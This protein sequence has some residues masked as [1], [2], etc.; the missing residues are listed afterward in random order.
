MQE[1]TFQ[2]R[3]DTPAE[4]RTLSNI[5]GIVKNEKIKHDTEELVKRFRGPLTA[6]WPKKEDKRAYQQYK[7]EHFPIA[8][9]S[10]SGADRDKDT[11]IT[12]VQHTGIINLDI[13]ENT[14]A[15]LDAFKKHLSDFPFIQFSALSVSGAVTGHLWANVIVTIPATFEDLP[16]ALRDAWPK[17]IWLDSLHKLY[18]AYAANLFKVQHGVNVGSSKDLKRARYLS[19]DPCPYSC[20][21]AEPITLE[22]VAEYFPDTI[23]HSPEPETPQKPAPEKTVSDIVRRAAIDT[24]S[25]YPHKDLNDREKFVDFCMAC[26]FE[27]LSYQE[28]DPI[29]R[30][31]EGYDSQGNQT[32]YDGLEPNGSKTFGSIVRL[33]KDSNAAYF[34]ERRTYYKNLDASHVDD[35]PDGLGLASKMGI[36]LNSLCSLSYSKLSDKIYINDKP[37]TD[38]AFSWVYCEMVN[39][40]F[41]SQE[42]IRQVMLREANRRQ[43]HPVRQFMDRLKW[44]GQ[45]RLTHDVFSRYFQ[46]KDF[47]FSH[48]MR[49]WLIGA[50]GKIYTGS[51]NPML[52]LVG[53][54]GRGKSYF[55]KFICPIKG[56]YIEAPILADNKDDLMR[57]AEK[58]V[59]EVSELGAT[60]KRQ[61]AEALKAFISR[62]VVTVRRP[63][64]KYDIERPA[65]ASFIGTVNNDGV[66]FLNDSTGNRRFR[67]CHM[68]EIDWSYSKELDSS[69]LWAEAVH[70]Y[71]AGETIQLGEEAEEA[72]QE[73]MSS[74]FEMKEPM[75]DYIHELFVLTGDSEDTIKAIDILIGINKAGYNGRNA[76][77][78]SMV[79]SKVAHKMGIE[80]KRINS[81]RAYVG[82]RRKANFEQE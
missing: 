79:L 63:Y 2:K 7:K 36:S 40:G 34:K 53:I 51:Q 71:R 12:P 45:E 39:R 17:E 25:Q 82:I 11:K 50:V 72:M 62:E 27:G 73:R 66:G 68:T 5:Y 16:A 33:A 31:N 70:L 58:I 67:A 64:D 43:F 18:I 76:R 38:P 80:R 35:I 48:I 60:T 15:E 42:M 65:L 37:I 59:W 74:S 20:Q 75:E 22:T 46:D 23:K 44:D 52:V 13:D 61:D 8:C 69:Q 21:K 47:I 78:D 49:K 10:L 29:F 41:K 32:I 28:I 77:A 19:F 1:I 3:I 57:S 24:L 9:F 14:K 81:Q 56:Y 30:K 54:Q 6:G 26:K 55:A 4:L